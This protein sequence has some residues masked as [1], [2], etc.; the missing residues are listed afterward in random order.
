[1]HSAARRGAAGG[2]E[3][4]ARVRVVPACTVRPNL[5][6]RTVA[7]V[8]PACTVR[9]SLVPLRR[10]S[11][12]S[13]PASSAAPELAVVPPGRAPAAAPPA[14]ATPHAADPGQGGTGPW[15]HRQP[16][17]HTFSPSGKPPTAE[18]CA[19]FSGPWNV[20]FGA[21]ATAALRQ[22]LTAGP[23]KRSL[24]VGCSLARPVRAR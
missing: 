11:R 10:M 14:S 5:G 24:L 18:H 7:W 4:A 22:L 12:D 13:A 17:Q 15:C 2:S 23:K 8:V 19:H 21:R 20:K 9:P 16:L 1:V 3:K 6:R